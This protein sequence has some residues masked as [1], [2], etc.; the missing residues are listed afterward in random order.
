MD[1]E[2]EQIRAVVGDK[3]DAIRLYSPEHR[4]YITPYDY[5]P[6]MLVQGILN[7][8]GGVETLSKLKQINRQ[9]I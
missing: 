8:I 3:L 6:E 1:K 4:R 9:V 5:R 2:G 7:A